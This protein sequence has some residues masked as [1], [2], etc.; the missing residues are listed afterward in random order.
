MMMYHDHELTSSQGHTEATATCVTVPY[1]NDLKSRQTAPSQQMLKRR[2]TL[3]HKC[4][5]TKNP[6]PG[7]VIH[8]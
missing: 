2:A 6:T 1:E 7:T 5:L 3:K 8:S 4:N